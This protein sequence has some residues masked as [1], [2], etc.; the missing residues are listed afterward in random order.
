M[1]EHLTPLTK[2]SFHSRRLSSDRRR[3]REGSPDRQN[4]FNKSSGENDVVT[5]MLDET[6]EEL[7][8]ADSKA[9]LLIA[10]IVAGGGAAFGGLAHEEV[11][12]LQHRLVL[13]IVF[14]VGVALVGASVLRLVAA[15]RPTL[16]PSP[17]GRVDYFGDVVR[18]AN[19]E[20]VE[21]SLRLTADEIHARNARQLWSLS[22]V[23]A[24]R[25]RAISTAMSLLGVGA[26]VIVAALAIAALAA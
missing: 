11:A 21:R 10:A 19:A 18:C 6:R 23:V 14:L 8:R 25:Y 2:W 16:K 26:V 12:L 13:A 1:E 15:V 5:R 22:H 7:S 24:K 3:H 9:N 4:F 20:I 17:A